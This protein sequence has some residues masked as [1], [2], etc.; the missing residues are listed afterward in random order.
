MRTK[1]QGTLDAILKFVNKY[2]QKNRVAPT[3]TDV[4]EGVGVARST[5]HRYLQELSERGVLNYDRGILSAPESAKMKT[6]YVSAPLVGSI[7]CGSPEEE[8][9]YVEEYVSLPVSMFGK[10]NIFTKHIFP[11]FRNVRIDEITSDDIYHWQ[12]AIKEAKSPQGKP[13][14]EAYLRTIQCQLNSIIN[15]ANSKGYLKANPLA[16]IKNMG[17][18]DKRVEFWTIDEYEKFAYQAMVDPEFYYCYEV[19]YW[20]GLREGEMLALTRN[21]IDF[22]ARTIRVNKT[23]SQHHGKDIVSTPK[24]ESSV[25]KVS[26]PDFLCDELKEYLALLYN[27]D[28]DERIFKC[29]KSTLT[30]HFRNYTE[31]AGLKPITIH[32]LRHSHVSLLIS[33]RYD[34][35]EVSKRIGHKSVKT[36]QDTY[37]HLFDE[38]QKSIA[39]DLDGMRRR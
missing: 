33:K 25:R 2:Y 29:T 19:L 36:T 23:L 14:S 7:Q 6:A 4:A 35:F 16:D 32:G 13:F 30:K 20:C 37:G 22:D 26:I 8:Q 1:D 5:T 34:I 12:L 39:N 9:E 17:V 24:T 27:N 31:L 11:T 3:I 10:K 38:V 21:D 15:Y 18:K 28:P